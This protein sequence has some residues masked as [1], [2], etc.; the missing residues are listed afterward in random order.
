MH[1]RGGRRK[2]K[3]SDE[4]DDDEEKK[5]TYSQD[6]ESGLCWYEYDIQNVRGK[7][8]HAE[9]DLTKAC[10]PVELKECVMYLRSE[11]YDTKIRDVKSTTVKE[12]EEE[13]LDSE[14]GTWFSQVKRS[15]SSEF[16]KYFESEIC[17]LLRDFE[18]SFDRYTYLSVSAWEASWI[19]L[20]ESLDTAL[21][22]FLVDML[23]EKL[24]VES[25]HP[26]ASEKCTGADTRKSNKYVTRFFES[27]PEISNAETAMF[28]AKREMMRCQ[29]VLQEFLGETSVSPS[30]V[31]P[32]DSPIGDHAMMET[33]NRQ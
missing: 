18:N 21:P 26:H 27:H 31:Y 5:V 11:F 28:E 17:V 7:F 6:E 2:K 16:C 1:G 3:K 10:P 15:R 20:W 19:S 29:R 9:S 4:D 33:V 22:Q 32:G 24:S 8:L 12:E 23:E 25:I 30:L 14:N 13:K